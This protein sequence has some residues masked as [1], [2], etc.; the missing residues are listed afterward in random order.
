MSLLTADQRK[1]PNP[2]AGWLAIA[3]AAGVQWFLAWW[4]PTQWP[5]LDWIAVVLAVGFA[6]VLLVRRW[7]F[8]LPVVALPE[9]LAVWLFREVQRFDELMTAWGSFLAPQDQFRMLLA[10]LALLLLPWS[11]WWLSRNLVPT[12]E[13]DRLS[14]LLIA[15][16]VVGAILDPPQTIWFWRWIGSPMLAAWLAGSTARYRFS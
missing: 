10:L 1:Q 7:I 11:K 14:F 8:V 6:A 12:D 15:I 9:R 16:L 3:V 4:Q 5:I 13:S 2:R